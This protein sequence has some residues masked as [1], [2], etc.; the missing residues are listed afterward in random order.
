MLH[1]ICV[2]FHRQCYI[3]IFGDKHVLHLYACAPEGENRKG[4][5][6]TFVTYS[7]GEAPIRN[8]DESLAWYR[9]SSWRVDK[10]KRR[11]SEDKHKCV[12]AQFRYKQQMELH[13]RTYVYV[14]ITPYQRSLSMPQI[15]AYLSVLADR[16]QRTRRKST[17]LSW[18]P[19]HHTMSQCRGWNPSRTGDRGS[20]SHWPSFFKPDLSFCYIR[21]HWLVTRVEVWMAIQDLCSALVS[22]SCAAQAAYKQARRDKVLV[23]TFDRLTQKLIRTTLVLQA[24]S[25]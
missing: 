6:N 8:F 19:H 23:K 4:R 18:W 11:Q 9:V 25:Q 3:A 14:L 10:A 21:R 24:N 15:E 1:R 22:L 16:K 7:L 5:Q 20:V 13:R 17:C 2:V 12:M